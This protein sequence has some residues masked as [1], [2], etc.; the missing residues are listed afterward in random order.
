MVCQIAADKESQEV[1]TKGA[2]VVLSICDNVMDAT[3]DVRGIAEFTN[4][5]SIRQEEMAK[6]GLRV[7]VIAYRQASEKE[8]GKPVAKWTCS[9]TGA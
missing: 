8:F 4:L 2:E 5:V 7:L 3:G 9:S 6:Q 1:Y